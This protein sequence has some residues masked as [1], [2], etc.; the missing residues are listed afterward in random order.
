[1]I[2]ND[3]WKSKLHELSEQASSLGKIT[4]QTLIKKREEKHIPFKKYVQ[5]YEYILGSTQRRIKL[6]SSDG[7]SKS[8]L[9][10]IAMAF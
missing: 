10:A 3:F 8:D 7:L 5:L 2:D 1:M 9:I 6:K 4:S